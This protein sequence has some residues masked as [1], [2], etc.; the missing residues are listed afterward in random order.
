MTPHVVVIG[1]G[2]AGLLASI[3]AHEAGAQVTLV[4]RT[5]D[6]GR[7]ILISGGGRCNVLPS[8]AATRTL[9]QRLVAADRAAPAGR[10]AASRAARDSSRRISA[11]P[12][13][14]EDETGSCSRHRT[15]L[16]TCA[17]V[18]SFAR[19]H[20]RPAAVRHRRHGSAPRRWRVGG[21]HGGGRAR[22]RPRDRRH[23]RPLGTADRQRRVRPRFWPA[24]TATWC[25]PLMPRSRR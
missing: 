17:T 25:S 16:A 18:S 2:A 1:A 9:R 3:A 19:D 14:V 24:R 21:G 4:E 7:K 10:L 23:W 15:G 11:I 8:H 6:G 22:R 5:A 12:L 20:G 13:A